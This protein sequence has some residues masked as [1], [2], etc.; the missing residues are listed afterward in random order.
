MDTYKRIGKRIKIGPS[1]VDYNFLMYKLEEEKR[2]LIMIIPRYGIFGRLKG[3][4]A[5]TSYDQEI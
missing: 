4:Y 3:F 1:P 5:Y 2:T